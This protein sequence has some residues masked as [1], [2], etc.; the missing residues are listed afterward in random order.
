M[1]K[2]A[3]IIREKIANENSSFFRMLSRYRHIKMPHKHK[4][5]LYDLLPLM[6]SVTYVVIE[7][8]VI[9]VILP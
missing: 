9:V 5:S 7:I 4:G 1:Y 8:V 2:D 3:P 6:F